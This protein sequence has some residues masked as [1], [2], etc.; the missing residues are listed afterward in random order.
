ML[1]W[2]ANQD[3]DTNGDHGP[4]Q[5]GLHKVGY[6][7]LFLFFPNFSSK[8]FP[9]RDQ[10]STPAPLTDTKPIKLPRGIWYPELPSCPSITVKGCLI[11]RM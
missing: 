1:C 2:V 6:F 7:L 10:G 11:H 5:A 9:V 8:G 3:P 4:T